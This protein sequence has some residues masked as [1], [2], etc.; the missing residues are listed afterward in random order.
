M[1][2]S[3][4]TI[5]LIEHVMRVVM[6]LAHHVVVL[7]HGEKSIEGTPEMVTRDPRTIENYLGRRRT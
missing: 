2:E 4:L 5:L 7:H 3:G 1:N 6:S